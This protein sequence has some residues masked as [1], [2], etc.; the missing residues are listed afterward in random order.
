LVLRP[1]KRTNNY[2]LRKMKNYSFK[3]LA[4]DYWIV[5]TA[6][7]FLSLLADNCAGQVQ[8]FQRDTP[9][10]DYGKMVKFTV[11]VFRETAP[12]DI[13]YLEL[14]SV[15]QDVI[16][17]EI[18][19]GQVVE[20]PENINFTLVAVPLDPAAVDQCKFYLDGELIQTENIPPYVI[21][22]DKSGVLTPWN[23]AAGFYKIEVAGSGESM[24]SC[25][26]IVK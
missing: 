22:G 13:D 10:D 17:M 12:A 25:N 7:L 21:N 18:Q 8:T 5:A 26:L 11:P 14:W 20:I 6:V 2:N 3:G 16:I 9:P 15:D 24:F 19:P 1:G 23:I 4:L